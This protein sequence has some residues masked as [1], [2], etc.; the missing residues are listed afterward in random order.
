MTTNYKPLDEPQPTLPPGVGVVSTEH[1]NGTWH[2]RH[3]E[4]RWWYPVYLVPEDSLTRFDYFSDP[5]GRAFLC[6]KDR[7]KAIGYLWR[8][9]R[10]G[11]LEYSRHWYVEV[12]RQCQLDYCSAG[13]TGNLY[14]RQRVTV[15]E[16][17]G[18][19]ALPA[20]DI[21][22]IVRNEGVKAGWAH[23]HT[24]KERS[25]GRAFF[26]NYYM[27]SLAHLEAYLDQHGCGK[28]YP[29]YAE[30]KAKAAQ[31]GREL[32]VIIWCA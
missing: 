27:L 20:S 30:A 12:G 8:R 14:Q 15:A 13:C 7:R 5:H 1:E 11:D 16:A 6:Y 18:R 22:K 25:K 3:K 19:L 24:S 21:K 9:W 17:A 10:R 2:L 23:L 28:G 29:S 32:P 26:H 31:E 4:H